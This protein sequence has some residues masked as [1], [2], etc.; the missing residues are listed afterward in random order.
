LPVVS[1]MGPNLL[2]IAISRTP[3]MRDW[4]FSFR[5]VGFPSGKDGASVSP[6]A[7]TARSISTVS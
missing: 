1:S 3:R 7:F 6:N 5:D 2:E 4:Y